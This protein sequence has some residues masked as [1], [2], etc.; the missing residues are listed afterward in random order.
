MVCPTTTTSKENTLAV[1]W[2]PNL[3]KMDCWGTLTEWSV[4]C[5]VW[6]RA[7]WTRGWR[8]LALR[9]QP[10]QRE[11][12]SSSHR[13][14]LMTNLSCPPNISAWATSMRQACFSMTAS[15]RGWMTSTKGL[16]NGVLLEWNPSLFEE[17]RHL[18]TISE[19]KHHL[20]W[21]EFYLVTVVIH[22]RWK[23]EWPIQ[24]LPS[25]RAAGALPPIWLVKVF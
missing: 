19:M 2:P 5:T 14:K 7:H 23:T 21:T 11:S 15:I 16:R 9:S 6:F 22:L 13:M 17:A 20:L 12:V 24:L 10:Q 1:H 18:S 4:R 8:A 25:R 3:T